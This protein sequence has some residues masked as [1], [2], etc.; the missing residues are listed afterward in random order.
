MLALLSLE[1]E[2]ENKDKL[3][4]FALIAMPQ[5]HAYRKGTYKGIFKRF[6]TLLCWTYDYMSNY[7]LPITII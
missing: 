5:T 2:L 6:Y 7:T 4:E 1:V 3:V